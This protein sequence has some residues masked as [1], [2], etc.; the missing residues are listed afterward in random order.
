VSFG[1][2][3]DLVFRSLEEKSDVLVRIKKDGSGRELLTTVPI[4]EKGSVSPD[5]E[6]VTVFSTGGLLAVPLHAGATR[7][8][9]AAPC[10]AVWASDGRFFYVHSDRRTSAASPGK[11]LAISVP[12]GK[13]LPD[14][15]ASGIDLSVDGIKLPGTRVIEHGA[16]SPGPDPSIYVFTKTDLQ[17]NLFRIALH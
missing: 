6:W 5:G 2:D 17:R 3:G 11:T 14:L 9:C 15:P 16:M 13:S 8:I 4:L 7:K 10:R 1:A 12:V